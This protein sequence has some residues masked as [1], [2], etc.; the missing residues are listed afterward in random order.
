MY[1]YRRLSM[2]SS[3]S[4]GSSLSSSLDSNSNSHSIRQRKFS[5]VTSHA[6]PEYP[7]RYDYDDPVE[8]PECA[9]LKPFIGAKIEEVM[10]NFFEDAL[11]R[12]FF[13]QP[14][15]QSP[16]SIF[17]YGKY[18]Q[19]RAK[20]RKSV[21]CAMFGVKEPAIPLVDWLG[22]LGQEALID[23]GL[24]SPADFIVSEH[25][26]HRQNR[27]AVYEA[28]E[29][30]SELSSIRAG[31][32]RST[33]RMTS[34]IVIYFVKGVFAGFGMFLTDRFVVPLLIKEGK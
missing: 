1:A 7:F 30:F 14:L 3:S 29:H 15:P 8:L 27:R 31:C 2:Q 26:S 19:E 20:I 11:F 21:A 6:A 16:L 32:L 10:D 24:S 17:F 25:L 18:R 28:A 34:R 9:P 4:S 22:L 13:P 23:A 12:K 33:W 5:S